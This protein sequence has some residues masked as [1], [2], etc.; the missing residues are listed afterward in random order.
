MNDLE[1][2]LRDA[3]DG[4]AR[5]I[6]DGAPPHDFG[7]VADAGRPNRRL[8]PLI[9]VAAAAAVAAAVAIPY[10]AQRDKTAPAQ[11]PCPGAASATPGLPMDTPKPVGSP[12]PGPAGEAQ[13]KF[14]SLPV[15]PP[16][17][18]PYVVTDESGAGYLQDGPSRVTLTAGAQT[19]VIDR[20]DCRW[21]VARTT[22]DADLGTTEFGILQPS[23]RFT[24]LGGSASRPGGLGLS[25]GL[26]P[27]GTQAAYTT[28]TAGNTARL[29]V[30]ELASGRE[31]TSRRVTADTAVLAWNS[32]GVWLH[33]G[34]GVDQP[35]RFARWVPGSEPRPV[36]APELLYP[37][38]STDLMLA[39]KYDGT[40]A[41]VRVLRAGA[42]GRLTELMKSCVDGSS[43]G[44]S[45]SPN[46]RVLI[47]HDSN[48]RQVPDG[49]STQ[50]PPELGPGPYVWEDDEHVLIDNGLTPQ[51]HTI[52]RCN[53]STGACERVYSS[54]AD[55]LDLRLLEQGPYRQLGF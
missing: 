8:S 53:V 55:K 44:P 3:L 19:K 13:R 38:R 29:V 36:D 39:Q 12:S 14:Q 5:T 1:N 27:D 41:C 25:V 28:L 20:L 46:G 49:A 24:R 32:R 52:A 7:A 16:P 21:L 51:Q 18:V 48:A 9:A 4:A 40:T 17:R 34:N 50:L 54:G 6:P 43:L 33:T 2:R 22:R 45:L 31:L 11:A 30:V 47:H 42:D 15:G 35:H 23:G 26:S 10:V 37:Y